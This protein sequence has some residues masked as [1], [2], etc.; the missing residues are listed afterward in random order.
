MSS[1]SAP[2][3][4][5]AALQCRRAAHAGISSRRTTRSQDDTARRVAIALSIVSAFA[6]S[7]SPST[8]WQTNTQTARLGDPKRP[9]TGAV[10]LAERKVTCCIALCNTRILAADLWPAVPTVAVAFAPIAHP[11]A[12]PRGRWVGSPRARAVIAVLAG[13]DARCPR[14][15]RCTFAAG[16]GTLWFARVATPGSVGSSS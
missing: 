3:Q 12:T 8:K 1:R 7:V 5:T 2:N 16:E 10:G 6:Q 13:I 9:C 14:R 15:R 11:M 4:R